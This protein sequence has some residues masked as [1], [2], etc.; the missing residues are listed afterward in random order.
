[1][2]TSLVPDELQ[3]SDRDERKEQKVYK[4]HFTF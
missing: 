2:L 4:N 3:E 1:M